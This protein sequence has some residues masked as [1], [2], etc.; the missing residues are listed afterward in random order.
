MIPAWQNAGVVAT[1]KH[2]RVTDQ[3]LHTQTDFA[4]VTKSK[5]DF[6]KEDL[7]PF[8]S[9]ITAGA[10]SVMIAHI[11]MQAV[12]PVLSALLSRKVVTDLLRNELGY[13]GLIIT[14]ALEMELS[15]NLLKNMIKFLLM[16]LL[17]K[18]EMI[19]S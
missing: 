13:N 10:D 15:S 12:D 7:L 4:V 2:F 9:G 19:A 17:L 16:F 1:L 6:E 8:K 11:V 5:A 18:Q 14:D 3:R